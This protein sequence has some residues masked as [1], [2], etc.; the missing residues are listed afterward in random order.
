MRVFAPGG[1]TKGNL[2]RK[3]GGGGVLRVE[4][5]ETYG[6]ILRVE[7]GCPQKSKRNYGKGRRV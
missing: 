7:G 4:P 5:E 1:D 3:R 2:E 6:W